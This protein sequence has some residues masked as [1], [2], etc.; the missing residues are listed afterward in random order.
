M[1]EQIEKAARSGKLTT[2]MCREHVS[3][4]Q[5]AVLCIQISKDGKEFLRPVAKL[6]GHQTE[7]LE[8]VSPPGTH[9]RI[10]G[11]H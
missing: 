1:L 8:D 10:N 2:V 4:A 3:G 5:V 9:R 6:Y 7:A 11:L